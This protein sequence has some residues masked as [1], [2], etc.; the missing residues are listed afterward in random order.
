MIRLRFLEISEFRL[1]FLFATLFICNV[2][3]YFDTKKDVKLR[4]SEQT[5]PN[6]ILIAISIYY[7]I[8]RVDDFFKFCTAY[9][10]MPTLPCLI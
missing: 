2:L 8:L 5:D 4:L 7:V 10:Y 1:I 6:N 9:I 3:P